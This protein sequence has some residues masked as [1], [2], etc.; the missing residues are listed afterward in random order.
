MMP[1][2]FHFKKA[3]WEKN[4]I[5]SDHQLIDFEISPAFNKRRFVGEEHRQT[6]G[7]Y[8]LKTH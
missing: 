7:R 8:D 6:H 1:G 5:R 3:T 2:N 4:M